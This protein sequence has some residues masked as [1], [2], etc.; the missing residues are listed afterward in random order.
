MK[1]LIGFLKHDITK[2]TGSN[3][4]SMLTWMNLEKL[5]GSKTNIPHSDME[6]LIYRPMNDKMHIC[7]GD[8]KTGSCQVGTLYWFLVQSNFKPN[9]HNY[10]NLHASLSFCLSFIT[11]RLI[12]LP[13]PAIVAQNFTNKSCLLCVQSE[14]YAFFDTLKPK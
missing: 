1:A 3:S 13:I 11:L 8:I 10:F 14:N 12:T 9:L 7:G 5:G 4:K 6:T 2:L